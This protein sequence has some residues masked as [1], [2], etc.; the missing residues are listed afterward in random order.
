MFG[1]NILVAP[2]L[3]LPNSMLTL[4][5]SVKVDYYLPTDEK[6]YYYYSKMEETD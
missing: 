1:G 2:K 6:W 5:N 4:S 3:E